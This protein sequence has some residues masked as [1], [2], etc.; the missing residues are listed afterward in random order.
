[1]IQFMKS[2]AK[3]LRKISEMRFDTDREKQR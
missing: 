3:A 2:A 1:V